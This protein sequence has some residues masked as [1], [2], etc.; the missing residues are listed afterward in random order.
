MKLAPAAEYLFQ[1]REEPEAKKL[2]EERAIS[3]G[4]V[5]VQFF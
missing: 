1:V 3:F 4:H 5:V 2:E